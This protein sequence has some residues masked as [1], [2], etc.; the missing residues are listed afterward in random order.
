[1]RLPAIGEV[2]SLRGYTYLWCGYDRHDRALGVL[3]DCP[4]SSSMYLRTVVKWSRHE[5]THPVIGKWV[6]L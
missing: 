6:I 1:V 2:W 4:G 3:I 5:L